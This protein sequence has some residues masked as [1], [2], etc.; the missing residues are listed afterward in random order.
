MA[1]QR[2]AMAI[3]SSDEDMVIDNVMVDE[4]MEWYDIVFVLLF[5]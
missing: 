3:L 5:K 1:S 4:M 2:S